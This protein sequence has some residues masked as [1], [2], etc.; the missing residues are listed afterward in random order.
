[1]NDEK[2]HT[3]PDEEDDT[4]YDRFGTDMGYDGEDDE[5]FLHSYIIQTQKIRQFI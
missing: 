3:A 1:M 5:V 4:D 2:Q